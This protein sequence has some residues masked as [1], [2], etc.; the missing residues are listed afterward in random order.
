MKNWFELE[1]DKYCLMNKHFSP[2]RPGPI[3]FIVI[4][5]NAG[6]DLS[7]EDCYRIWQDREASAHYQVETDGTIGQLVNDWDV[8]WHAGNANANAASIGIEHANTAGAAA[9]W[10]ISSET[11]DNGAHLVAA[12]CHAYDLGMP[13]W[14]SNVFPH[15]YFSQTSCP[16]QLSGALRDRYMAAARDHY[17]AMATN[18]TSQKDTTV[19]ESDRQ[20]LI[21]TRDLCRV[22]RDQLCGPGSGY[23]GWPQTG[24]RTLTDTVAAIA[25]KQGIPNT[26]DTMKW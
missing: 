23:P 4:H 12:L 10:P 21:E 16:Y 13:I 20:L 9:S 15:S 1:P 19:T 7:T 14:E 26:K 11:I 5:H 6:I 18:A 24:G 17:F 2:G 25:E 22:I 8:A 3:E